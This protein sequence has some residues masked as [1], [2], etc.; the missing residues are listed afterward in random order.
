MDAADN[1]DD[2]RAYVGS[3]SITVTLTVGS[4][5]RRKYAIELPIT[6]PPTMTTLE[7]TSHS[8]NDSRWTRALITARMLRTAAALRRFAPRHSS[9]QKRGPPRSTDIEIDT[10][11]ER[12][13]R[14]I[15]DRIR[16]PAHIRLPR[17]GAGFATAAGFLLAAERT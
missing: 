11:R 6:P 7:L 10:P 14:R 15:V 2:E 16:R 5:R 4:D 13:R 17:V 9:T 1:A 12:Q 3:R 8:T